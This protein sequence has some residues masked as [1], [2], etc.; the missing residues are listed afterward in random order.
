MYKGAVFVAIACLC[1]V[2]LAAPASALPLADVDIGARYWSVS[3]SGDLSYKGDSLDLEDNLDFEREGAP[4][5]Y[6]RAHLPMLVLEAHYTRLDFSGK[7]QNI[8]TSTRFGRIDLNNYTDIS[9]EAT[10]DMLHGGAM[11]NFSVPWVDL[12]VGAG[13]NYIDAE[14]EIM[15]KAN[16]RKKTATGSAEAPLPVV[17]ARAEI[18]PPLVGLHLAVAGEGLSYS[19]NSFYDLRGTVG[20]TFQDLFIVDL[21]LEGGYRHIAVDYDEEDL[22]LDSSF[23]GPF[24]GLSLA[25]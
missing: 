7:G 6:A 15:A 18:T 12:G 16:N 22:V 9:T 21:R 24:A 25:F 23:S 5:A 17:K 2:F 14:A 20:Y 4:H 3:P 13:V 11:L 8:T 10:M 19:G 1:L